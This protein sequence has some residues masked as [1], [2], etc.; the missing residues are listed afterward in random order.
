MPL[1]ITMWYQRAIRSDFQIAKLEKWLASLGLTL[2][3]G[4]KLN[5]EV[6]ME[7]KIVLLSTRQNLVH[8]L[9]SLLHE[10]GHVMIRIHPKEFSKEYPMLAE[11]EN[12][13]LHKFPLRFHMEEVKE[14]IRAWDNGLQLAK[15]L[16]IPISER[17]YFNFA[18]RWVLRYMAFAT[19]DKKWLIR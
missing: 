18:S 14:E 2:V 5:D 19:V 12:R 8:Q 7:K 10:C 15:K 4:K 6:F 9:Y 16:S 3:K 11:L 17:E 1:V 13:S